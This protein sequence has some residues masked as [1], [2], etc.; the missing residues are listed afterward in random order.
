VPVVVFLHA[1]PLN[2]EMWQPQLSAMPPGWAGLAPDFRG[3]GT[4]LGDE[5]ATR[6]PTASTI[7]DDAEDV[8]A[9]MDARH[10]DRAVVCGCSMGGYVA[11]A[12]AASVPHA[13]LVVVPEAGHL[14]NLETPDTF[15]AALEEFLITRVQPDAGGSIRRHP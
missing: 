6:P 3:F 9:L 7:D 4:N 12:L 1:F 8:V 11:M 14:P 5:D 13:L 15:N 10:V 2:S